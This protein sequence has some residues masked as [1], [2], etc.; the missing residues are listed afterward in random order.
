MSII[1]ANKN[2]TSISLQVSPELNA[3][4]ENM[5]SESHSTKSDVMLKAIAMMDVAIKAKN[6][7]QKVGI[8]DLNDNLVNE[9]VGI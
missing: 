7:N 4:L 3:L 2:T 6:N 5:A 8:L 9:I 1:M